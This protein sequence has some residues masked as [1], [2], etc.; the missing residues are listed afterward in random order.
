MTIVKGLTIT[1]LMLTLAIISI[2]GLFAGPSISKFLERNKVESDTLQITNIIT[3]ARSNAISKK[4]P[5][6]I[7]GDDKTEKCS[8]NWLRLKVINASTNEIMHQTT[9][10]SRFSSAH[11]SAFQNKPGLTIAPTGFTSHQNGTLYLC[12]KRYKKLHRAIIVSKSGRVSIKRQ[13]TEIS[14][15]CNN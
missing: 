10:N 11:W 15:K 7:C 6:T 12:H 14:R 13:S 1:E 5:I 8:R 2:I 3:T 4:S 9:L